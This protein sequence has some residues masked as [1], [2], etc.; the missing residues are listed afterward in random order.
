[1]LEPFFG[2]KRP[3]FTDSRA[4][5]TNILHF[6]ARVLVTEADPLMSADGSHCPREVERRDGTANDYPP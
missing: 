4:A 6:P 5:S 3:P 2:F 1:M